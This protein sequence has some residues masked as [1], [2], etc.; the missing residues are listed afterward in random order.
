MS[1]RKESLKDKIVSILMQRIIDGELALG[2]KIREA[3]L[4]KEF[5]VSQS[6]VREAITTLVVLGILEHQPNVGTHVRVCNQEETIEIYEVRE[7]LELF[8]AS[9]AI[10]IN[11][12]QLKEAYNG[13][14]QSAKDNDIH[15][16]VKYDQLVHA[17]L[18]HASKNKLLI[19]LW[20]QQYTR[21]SVQ[22]V[23]HEFKGNLHEIALMHLPIVNAIESKNSKALK[24]ALQMHYQQII[25]TI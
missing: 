16:F 12:T 14:L 24:S 21:S 23:I 13:M 3:H 11:I 6:P 17:A 19:E 15:S 20:T 7:A 9:S 22:T 2:E 1:L 5:G 4:A 18:V 25:K 10:D 8:V